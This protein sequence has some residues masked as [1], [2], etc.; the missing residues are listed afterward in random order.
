MG[1]NLV[2]VSGEVRPRP[3]CSQ[4][5]ACSTKIRR[6]TVLA[7]P[8]PRGSPVL[9]WQFSRTLPQTLVTRP[10]GRP[11]IRADDPA[12]L[13]AVTVGERETGRRGNGPSRQARRATSGRTEADKSAENCENPTF[14]QSV[15]SSRKFN[16]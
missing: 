7:G 10:P 15:A 8:A 13:L 12:D 5:F 14:A 16:N 11:Q 2:A 4:D 9:D 6:S 1:L 3:T